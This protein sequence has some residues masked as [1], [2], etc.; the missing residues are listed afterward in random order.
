MSFLAF[1]QLQNTL[2]FSLTEV[3]L[4]HPNFH[5]NQ[6]L[7]WQKKGYLRPIMRGWYL[8]ADVPITEDLC[9]LLANKIIAPS[10]I[11][12]EYVFSLHNLIPEGVFKIT[13]ITTKKTQEY[14]TD[15]AVFNYRHVKPNL[16]FGYH[17]RATPFGNCDVAD[18]EKAILDFLY[19]TPSANGK[20]YFDEMRFD[21][22]VLLKLDWEKLKT[23]LTAFDSRA[24]EKRVNGLLDYVND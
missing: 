5:V 3:R 18:L 6:L 21:Q 11:S 4:H 19:L 14:Q 20:N 17:L 2:F 1:R 9:L 24:L 7:R 10:Y 15:F 8:Y 23:Y 12:M 13:S 16:F 22:E